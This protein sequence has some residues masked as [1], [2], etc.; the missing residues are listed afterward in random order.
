MIR[1]KNILTDKQNLWIWIAF[2]SLLQAVLSYA[3]EKT[4][5]LL[6]KSYLIEGDTVYATDLLSSGANDDIAISLGYVLFSILA[7]YYFI[8]QKVTPAGRITHIVILIIQF[9]F[10]VSIEVGS[11]FD[12][13]MWGHNFILFVWCINYFF[14]IFLAFLSHS[15]EK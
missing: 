10:L 6:K 7:L 11:I 3:F 12:T 14:L 15:D 4:K 13:I 8:R 5:G 1:F 2:L 9:L